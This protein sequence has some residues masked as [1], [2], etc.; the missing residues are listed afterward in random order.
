MHPM[1]AAAGMD[2]R[3]VRKEYGN[4]MAFLGGIDK[5]ELAKDRKAIDMEVIPKVR[6]MMDSGGGII[7]SCDHAVPPDI[8]L[9]N[10]LYFRD[11]V[12]QLQ[13]GN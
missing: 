12:R 5:R 2:V 4:R 10:Y 6:D 1:E 11:L 8:P 7:V 13:E 3:R 9:S